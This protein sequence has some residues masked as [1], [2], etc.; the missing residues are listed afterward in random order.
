LAEATALGAEIAKFDA[1]AARWWD[2]N[3][4][5]KPLHRM[6]PVR[7][8]WIAERLA[9]A[10]RRK[11]GGAAPLA[12]LRVLDVGCGAGLASEALARLG[13]E[14][15]GMDAAPEA[16]A[17]ARAHAEA[18]ALAIDYRLGGPEDLAEEAGGSGIGIAIVRPSRR[19]GRR[20]KSAGTI[21]QREIAA[22]FACWIQG[23]MEVDKSLALFD[24]FPDVGKA[25][26]ASRGEVPLMIEEGAVRGELC[27]IIWQRLCTIVDDVGLVVE[28]RIRMNMPVSRIND[29]IRTRRAVRCD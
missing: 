18:G 14:V 21:R 2:P 13:A 7:I 1:L 3:G 28:V 10:H 11:P 25:Q 26:R 12:G 6:N 23:G 4:P 20:R 16:L 8:G 19:C 22:D 17:A 9:R 29:S 27:P 24:Q 15:T 5:M